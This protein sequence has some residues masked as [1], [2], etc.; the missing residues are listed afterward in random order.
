MEEIVFTSGA[1]L[2]LFNQ[3]Q[4]FE[5][6]EFEVTDNGDTVTLSVDGS[7]YTLKS[8]VEDVPADVETIETISD[9][10]EEV[11]SDIADTE[12]AVDINDMDTEEV[13]ESG[14][15]K[16]AIKALLLGGMIKLS[17]KLLK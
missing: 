16:E 11:Y 1:L 7:T 6:H 4:E 8:A 15:V 13:V 3:I 17:S 2:E 5:G 10:D 12:S 9:I 14:I